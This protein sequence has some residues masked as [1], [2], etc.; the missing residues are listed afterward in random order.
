MLVVAHVFFMRYISN[1]RVCV[2]V[3]EGRPKGFVPSS[4]SVLLMMSGG[5][6]QHMMAIAAYACSSPYVTKYRCMLFVNL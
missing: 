6:L 2:I 5:C 1:C 4:S 3:A